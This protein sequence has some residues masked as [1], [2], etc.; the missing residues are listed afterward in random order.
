MPQCY[1]IIKPYSI[2]LGYGHARCNKTACTPLS[3]VKC[4]EEGKPTWIS[5]IWQ[6]VM[7]KIDKSVFIPFSF[8]NICMKRETIAKRNK[9]R[10]V[11]LGRHSVQ[12]KTESSLQPLSITT[13]WCINQINHK[14]TEVKRR[15]NNCKSYMT[16]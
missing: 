16:K 3:F 10:K 9:V 7:L 15:H 13:I 1:N 5:S 2:Y 11:E 8:S 12:E 4:I 14:R 6:L